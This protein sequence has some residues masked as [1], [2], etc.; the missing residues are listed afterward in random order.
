ME[1]IKIILTKEQLSNLQVFLNRV[2]LKGNE[3]VAFVEI[4][5]IVNNPIILNKGAE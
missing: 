2:D 3:V 5:N 1:D 4:I